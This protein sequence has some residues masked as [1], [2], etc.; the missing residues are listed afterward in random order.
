MA[1]KAEPRSRWCGCA[2]ACVLSVALASSVRASDWPHWR[3]PK[4]T[5]ISEEKGWLTTWPQG[6]PKKLWTVRVGSGFSS[7]AVADGRVYTMGNTGNTDTVWCLKAE[8]G[9]VVWKHSYPCPGEFGGYPGPRATPTVDGN[10]VYTMSGAGHLLCLDA[11]SGDV[12]WAK[13][14]MTDLKG[15]TPGAWWGFSCSPF[16]DGDLLIVPVGP[17]VALK[18]ATGE[19]V[20]SS[21]DYK[22]SYA[23]AYAFDFNG[24][25][26]V[27]VFNA[28]GLVVVAET[29]GKEIGKLAWQTS[30]DVNAVTPIVSGDKIFISSGYGVGC[31]LV[32]ITA[33]GL[34]VVWRNR[35]MKNHFNSCV[36]W[37]GHL[38]GMDENQ[39]RCMEFETGAVKWSERSTGKG[40]LIIADGKIIAMS[41]SGDLIV[42]EAVPTGF[43][44]LARA[45]VLGGLCWTTPALANGLV[46]CRNREGDL[47]CV[48][49]RAR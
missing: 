48:D 31:A 41:D 22:A 19:I 26:L 28:F 20:W 17:T 21:G 37:D 33:E 49:L 11:K 3:G 43:K 10:R 44:P 2:L 6:G 45:K 35:D 29:D 5:G 46:Y 15:R 34:K 39:L 30:Y 38:Y 32:Q 18:K 7:V 36:L 47:A 42:A 24:Q 14:T 23:T 4:W 40:S 9:E 12:I 8:T 13:S 25:R 1:R 27:A 16:I